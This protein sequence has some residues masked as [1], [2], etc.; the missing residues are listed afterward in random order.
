[1]AHTVAVFGE[2]PIANAL[3][4]GVSAIA[5]RGLGRLA[6]MHSRSIRAWS[7]RR[8]LRADH[9]RAHREQRDLVRREV[10]D[11]EQAAGDHGDRHRAGARGDQHADQHRVD[12]TEQEQGQEHP[13]LKAG[14]TAE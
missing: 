8:L 14:I 13:G 6:W 2:R 9:A 11:Q 5:T 3:G 1:M 7:S 4:I 12:E 10:L